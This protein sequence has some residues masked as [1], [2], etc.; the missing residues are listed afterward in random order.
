[1]LQHF[2]VGQ[3]I[4]YRNGQPSI[5]TGKIV[6]IS[7]NSL[8]VIDDEAGMILWNSGYAVGSCIHPNQVIEKVN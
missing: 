8:V 7:E 5:Y 6:K 4:K 3:V 2:K 1:M